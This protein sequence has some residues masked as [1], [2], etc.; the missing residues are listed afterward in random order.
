MI[1]E[2]VC[3]KEVRGK[4]LAFVEDKLLKFYHISNGEVSEISIIDHMPSTNQLAYSSPSRILY[5]QFNREKDIFAVYF[6]D[7]SY[8][9]IYIISAKGHIKNKEL[10]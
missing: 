6:K 5:N 3:V 1:K 8:H 2:H 7:P 4:G 10:V 9:K